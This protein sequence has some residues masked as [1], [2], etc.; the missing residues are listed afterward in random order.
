VLLDVVMPEL[1]GIET[2]ARIRKDQ[3]YSDIPIL[4][5]T[6]LEDMGSLNGA[7]VAGATDYVTKPVN[8]I[9]L[10]ARVRTAN[11]LK[12]EL[13]RRQARE[14]EL[15]SFVSSWGDRRASLWVDEATGLFVGEVAEA[16]LMATPEVPIEDTTAI[17][18][19]AI[20]QL[21]RYRSE[22][23]EATTRNLLAAVGHTVRSTIATIG[24]MAATYRNGVIVL[25][26]PQTAA[27]VAR[28]LGEQ[29]CKAISH[30]AVANA[31]AAAPAHVTASA[32]VVSGRVQRGIDR[33]HLL[34]HAMSTVKRAVAEG[35]NRIAVAQL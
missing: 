4:M 6:S 24:V 22:N 35:G 32:S 8:R 18:A 26:V 3:R 10:L 16:Y 23:G 13:E 31:D 14:R 20:D 25:V 30:L 12:S 33:A 34:T 9:E 5:V 1:D 7:F 15:L 2:C 17:I 27:S 11:K 29:L 28:K 21:D 19:I